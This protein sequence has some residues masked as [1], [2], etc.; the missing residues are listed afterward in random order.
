[1]TYDADMDPAVGL[2]SGDDRANSGTPTDMHKNDVSKTVPIPTLKSI[3]EA[4][5]PSF[6]FACIALRLINAWGKDV[7]GDACL[8]NQQ[9]EQNKHTSMSVMTYALQ[10]IVTGTT[11]C[12][13]AATSRSSSP[14][15]SS[16]SS[17]N[18]PSVDQSTLLMS[19]TIAGVLASASASQ[20]A[21]SSSSIGGGGGALAGLVAGAFVPFVLTKVSYFCYRYHVTATMTNILCG[22]GVSMLVGMLMHLSGLAHGL[23]VFTGAIRSLIRWE[24]LILPENGGSFQWSWLEKGIIPI[25]Q[26]LQELWSATV[27]RLP[28]ILYESSF[29]QAP[30]GQCSSQFLP[31]PMGIGFLYGCT[32]VYG[33]KVGWYHSLFLPLILLEMDSAGKGEE[34]SLFGAIDECTLVMVCAGI[35]VGNLVLPP[36]SSKRKNH[37][38][39]NAKSGMASL[40][41]QALRTNVL[42]GDFIEAAYPSMERSTI[43]NGSAYVAAGLS[44]EILLQRRVLSTAYLPLPMAVWISNDRWGMGIACSVA[45]VV[46]L[47]GTLFSNAISIRRR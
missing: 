38:G 13:L 35:C 8:W 30:D 7:T 1:M 42:C 34:A 21:F 20:S 22:G 17:P 29:L 33:S 36:S 43:I 3:V 32:F 24:K 12:I 18:N 41:W 14:S 39:E 40:S 31:I 11:C 27:S 45:F 10:H 25:L 9:D 19:A 6:L 2:G 37:T 5:L 44:T 16:S 15:A 4:A 28:T 26:Y 47:F 23:A 46:S